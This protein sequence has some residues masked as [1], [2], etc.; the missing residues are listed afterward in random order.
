M[1]FT[2]PSDDVGIQSLAEFKTGQA[3]DLSQPL[4]FFF[5]IF[6]FYRRNQP[7][8]FQMANNA[9]WWRL[10]NRDAIPWRRIITDWWFIK[11]WVFYS[12][13]SSDSS[14]GRYWRNDHRM[15]NTQPGGCI[16]QGRVKIQSH[17]DM[18]VSSARRTPPLPQSPS[19]TAKVG[20]LISLDKPE[21]HRSTWGQRGSGSSSLAP[22]WG[23]I[24]SCVP[25]SNLTTSE[26]TRWIQ[27]D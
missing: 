5:F 15:W 9:W 4:F 20:E 2:S 19:T 12:S 10:K 6:S 27:I 18:L 21:E 7:E 14:L 11:C 22:A 26:A 25:H 24:G 23:S 3:W 8:F 17:R 16:E 13:H 1:T